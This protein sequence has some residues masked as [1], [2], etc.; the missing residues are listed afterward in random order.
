MLI[1]APRSAN[2][3][4]IERVKTVIQRVKYASVSIDGK[5]TARIDQGLMILLGIADD[6]DREAADW[7][8]R[9]AAALRIF[10]DENGVMNKD[11]QEIDGQ[12]LVVS[13]FTLLASYKKG[14]RPSYIHAAGHETAIPLYEYFIAQLAAL[15]GKPVAT[16]TFGADMKIELLNDGPVTICMDTKRKE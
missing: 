11:I 7:L 8:A 9:K 13:Q 12:I 14:N 5:V 2:Q 3:V 10:D 6:D 16:G 4:T 1:A 15:T